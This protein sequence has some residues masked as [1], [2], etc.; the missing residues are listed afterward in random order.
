MRRSLSTLFTLL[1]LAACTPHIEGLGEKIRVADLVDDHYIAE[2]GVKLPLRIWE[3]VEAPKA[4]LIGV[5]GFNDYGNFLTP[6]METYLQ[7][8]AIKLITYDQRG[9]GAAPHRGLWAGTEAL[10]HD[11]ASIIHLVHARH[12]KLPLYVIGESMGGAVVMTTLAKIKPLPVTGAILSAPAVWGPSTWPWYQKA[13]LYAVS[14]TM[15][16]LKLSGG[17]IV[18]PTDHIENWKNWSLDPLV[19][20]G[21]RVDGLWGISW[22]MQDALDHTSDLKVPTLVLYGQKDE[23]I[24][25]GPTGQ[26][27]S[28]LDDKH[29]VAFY[30]DGWHWLPRDK[31]GP[32][33]W[34]DVVSWIGDPDKGL[35]SGADVGAREKII[36]HP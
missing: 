28:A 21:T 8:N 7:Q 19:I 33:V 16:W 29:K 6:G 22:L 5:H 4:I 24:P 34:K 31:N 18:Q 2:D 1:F 3:P 27:I 15:P 9:F 11:L 26:M 32:V 20:R 23:L 35:P 14:Y 36:Q 12:E 10:T 17:G 25:M 30:P 13:S